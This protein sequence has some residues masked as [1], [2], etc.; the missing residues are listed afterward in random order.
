MLRKAKAEADAEPDSEEQTT[1]KRR[2][3]KNMKNY[4]LREVGS[5][6]K[7]SK[8]CDMFDVI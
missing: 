1:F 3:K 2:K 4:W 8:T 6:M 5:F 7:S